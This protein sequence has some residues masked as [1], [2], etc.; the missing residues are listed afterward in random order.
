MAVVAADSSTASEVTKP[1]PKVKKPT[2]PP[3]ETMIKEAIYELDSKI[4]SSKAA[5]LKYVMRNYEVGQDIAKVNVPLCAALKRAVAKGDIVQVK[6]RGAL[7]SFKLSS[8]A[9]A[10]LQPVP[11]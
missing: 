6:G 5:I 11:Q 10:A 1:K 9:E 4:G 3:Y 8:A 7:G 2:H